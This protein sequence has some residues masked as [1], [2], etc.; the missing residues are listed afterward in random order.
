MPEII[1]HAR[2]QLEKG[3]LSLGANVRIGRTPD[4]AK[5]FKVAG[6]DW[7]WCDLEHTVVPLDTASQIALCAIDAG[8]TP[9]IRV[10][11]HSPEEINLVLTNGFLGVIVPHVENA[12]Q[13]AAV[14]RP[15]RFAPRGDR[16]A[17]NVYVHFGY[18][19]V[20]HQEAAAVL[21][22]NTLCAVL[23]ESGEAI[24][25]AEAIAAVDGVDVLWVGGTDLGFDLGIPAQG[26][27]QL[28]EDACRTVIA[29]AR[30]H[31]KFPGIGGIGD[32]AVLKRYIEMG[33]RFISSGVDVNFL[34]TG[35]KARS[36]WLRSISL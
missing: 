5:V 2:R 33:M 13:A 18:Q 7:V 36:R 19:P 28:I 12:E 24:R 32:D 1:N 26:G 23:L 3:Q 15:C 22:D 21:N 34:A 4:I 11:R 30:K 27:H 16:S 31:G 25:N 10:S 8:I 6:F 20:S 14:A 29:A 9:L 35:A 17:P